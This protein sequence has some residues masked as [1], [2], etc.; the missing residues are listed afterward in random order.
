MLYIYE[1]PHLFLQDI[2]NASIRID[3]FIGSLSQEGLSNQAEI[4]RLNINTVAITPNTIF[5]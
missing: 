4:S 5:R 2:L 1:E 3:R